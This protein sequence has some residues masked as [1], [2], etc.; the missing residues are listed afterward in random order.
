MKS[1]R[2][3]LVEPGRFE[4]SEADVA[5]AMDEV[6]VKVS[7][8]GLCNWEINHWKGFLGQYP[9]TLGH[10]YGG[11]VV[12]LGRGTDNFTEGDLV[13]GL[14][15]DMIGFSDYAV[16]HK[17][18]CFKLK[19]N[20]DPRHVLGEPLKCVVTVLRGAAPEAGDVGIM[21]G[22]GP[23]G[24][25]CIQ[26]LS[27][28]SLSALIALDID[29]EKLKLAKAFGATHVI[30]TRT[31]DAVQV[32]SEIT[33]GHMVDFV[34]EGTGI[35]EILNKGMYYLKKGRGRLILMSSH[36]AAAASGFDFRPAVER[37]LEIRVA[38]PGYSMD[39]T[40]DMRRA[41]VF[42]NKGVFRM[43]GIVSHIFKLE[44]IQKAFETLE[45]KPAGYMK[46]VVTP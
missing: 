3:F 5:P 13:T 4:I 17:S 37:S 31:Q 12:A 30:N 20:F 21:L 10:E 19:K 8:C 23:M 43:D 42:M 11:T 15:D 25:W 39:Q 44:N 46:G 27:G 40:E 7:A 36:E 45:N 1:R 41:A 26:G 32:I 22:C 24:L 28:N 34:I 9:Q 33:G 18:K 29:D 16:F 2:A 35:P 6:M 14:G 38:H